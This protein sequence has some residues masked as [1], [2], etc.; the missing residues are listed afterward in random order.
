VVLSVQ[1]GILHVRNCFN[2][3]TYLLFA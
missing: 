3:M 2:R 1:R